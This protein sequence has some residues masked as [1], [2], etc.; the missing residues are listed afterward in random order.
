MKLFLGET[1]YVGIE[2]INK[3][4]QFFEI[5][6]AEYKIYD[7]QNNEL[8]RGI[9]V[10]QEKQIFTLFNASEKGLYYLDFKYHIGPE[11]LKARILV[12]VI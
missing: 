10:V 5:E 2:V 4:G 1:R 6:A 12:E 11:V 3:L 7:R 9:P 8:S